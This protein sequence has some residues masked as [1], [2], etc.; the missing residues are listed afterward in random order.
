MEGPPI[1]LEDGLD[2][3]KLITSSSIL[4]INVDYDDL[5]NFLEDDDN[6]KFDLIGEPVESFESLERDLAP[7]DGNGYVKK[8]TLE[9]GGGM[10]LHEGCTVYIA[11]SG[12]W[13][14]SLEP[15]DIWKPNKPLLCR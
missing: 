4:N 13:E 1:V 15:F 12:Y 14:N 11:Y 2:L 6:N 10:P 5:D 7:I 3:Q 9:E 8:K